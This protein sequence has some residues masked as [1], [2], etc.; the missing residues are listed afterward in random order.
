M[1][2]RDKHVLIT[3][4]AL[5][6]GAALSELFANLGAKVIIHCNNS[7]DAAEDLLNRLPSPD[8]HRILRADFSHPE[9]PAKLFAAAGHVDILINCAS[10]FDTL[11]LINES[12]EE[13]E[14]QL[15]VNFIAPLE[16]MKHFAA[17]DLSEG[18]IVNFTD[19]RTVSCSDGS[20]SY[21]LSK[22]SLADATLM[23]AKQFAP[24][25][26]VNAIAPGPVLPPVGLES[27]KGMKKVL[28]ELPLARQVR[29]ED[30]LSACVFLIENES[31]TGQI[32]FIDSGQHLI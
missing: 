28:A 2:I 32:L 23:A 8:N 13:L 16:L 10:V 26:R 5:R 4:G 1:Q 12:L 11:P 30:I 7:L 29:M 27:G 15:R 18:C 24:K 22:K 19:Q 20:G 31:V 14:K 25:V 9:A 21:L 6:I 3:G 17:Q